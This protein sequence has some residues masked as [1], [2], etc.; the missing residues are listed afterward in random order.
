MSAR[1]LLAQSG[2]RRGCEHRKHLFQEARVEAG[3]TCGAPGDIAA[4]VFA[5]EDVAENGVAV[6]RRVGSAQVGGTIEIAAVVALAE[7]AEER[8]E[9]ALLPGVPLDATRQRR[10]HRRTLVN[11]PAGRT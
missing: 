8:V 2:H 3:L 11:L 9:A 7:G 5:A 1:R 10:Q 4:D 6:E